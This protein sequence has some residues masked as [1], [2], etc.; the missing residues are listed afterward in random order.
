MNL[1]AIC[2]PSDCQTSV[3]LDNLVRPMPA[4]MMMMMTTMVRFK[5][6]HSKPNSSYAKTKHFQREY[7]C[8][9]LTS[10]HFVCVWRETFKNKEISVNLF[11]VGLNFK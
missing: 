9:F 4:M 5:Q 10:A 3:L 11:G 7:V 8:I 2:H 1:K 6:T